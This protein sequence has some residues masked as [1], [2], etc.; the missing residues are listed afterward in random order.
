MK[1]I[2]FL[3]ILIIFSAAV[4]ADF[5]PT[6]DIVQINAT[7]Y[8]PLEGGIIYVKVDFNVTDTDGIANLNNSECKCRFDNNTIWTGTYESASNTSCTNTTI[9]A[10]IMQYTCTVPMNYW[11]QPT[12]YSVNVSIKDN[13]TEV[14]NAT[15]TFVYNILAASSLDTSDINFGLLTS[16]NYSTNVT[17]LNSPLTINNT[18]NKQLSINVTGADRSEER[19]V[20]K[21]CRSRWS[22]Y[23]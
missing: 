16:S 19:R 23:H 20:G 21:E 4:F 15:Q 8:D 17:D 12:T 9:N 14:S 11:Y 13:S 3:L 18:G 1:N 5:A 6:I 7:D 10:T 22:P 2:L